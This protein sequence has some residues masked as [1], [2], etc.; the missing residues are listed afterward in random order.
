ME[1]AVDQDDSMERGEIGKEVSETNGDVIES[2][3]EKLPIW[4]VWRQRLTPKNNNEEFIRRPSIV[5][6]LEVD[7]VGYP[8]LA[9]VLIS[10]EDL[11]LYRRFTYLQSR[12]LLHKQDELRVLE[13]ELDQM[14]KFDK[15]NNPLLL[16]SREFDDAQAGERKELLTRIETKF[17]EYSNLLIKARDLTAFACPRDRDYR[18]MRTFFDKG[19]PIRESECY[20][21]H[22]EDILTLN[23]RASA[24]L[25]G[26]VE[27]LL[28]A[29]PT[30]LVQF[31]FSNSALVEK[32]DA[33]ETGIALYSRPSIVR[34]KAGIIITMI[35]AHFAGPVYLLWYMARKKQT[36]S[37]TTISVAILLTFTCT[38]SVVLSQFTRVKR[39]ELLASAAAYCAV[40]VVFIG[41][42]KDS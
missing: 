24:W 17:N 26:A 6:K 31:F 23:G 20:I 7:H 42:A 32:S 8:R 30:R 3:N 11:M 36:N 40:L 2:T 5:R 29:L 28:Q 35:L 18:T 19:R 38:F 16:M 37:T 27:Y 13:V 9:T 34:F 41:N 14:D 10:D 33:V 22:E 1:K 15:A 25:D 4:Q 39:H 12:L 21:Y